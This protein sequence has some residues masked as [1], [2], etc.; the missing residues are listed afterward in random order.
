MPTRLKP[1]IFF[2]E[3]EWENGAVSRIVSGGSNW[4]TDESSEVLCPGY[5]HY[6]IPG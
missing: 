6:C 3:D 4:F 5:I 1:S 2:N